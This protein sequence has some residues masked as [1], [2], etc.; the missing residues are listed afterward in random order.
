MVSNTWFLILYLL[1]P[2][3][4]I[5]MIERASYATQ[6]ECLVDLKEVAVEAGDFNFI[7]SCV[8]K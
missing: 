2:A 5:V 6:A 4:K 7:A 1:D 8:S 3:G